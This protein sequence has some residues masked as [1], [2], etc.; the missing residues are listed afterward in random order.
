MSKQY[1]FV[2]AVEDSGKMF[3]DYEASINFDNGEVW[4][5]EKEVWLASHD[6]SVYDQYEQAADKLHTLL[7]WTH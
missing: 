6:E 2:V 7:K 5:T 3:I 4:D 1:H